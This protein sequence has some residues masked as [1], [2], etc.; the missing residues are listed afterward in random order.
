MLAGQQLADLAG[1]LD[2]RVNAEE[3]V[4]AGGH[5]VVA[6]GDGLLAH[7]LRGAAHDGKL[8]DVQAGILRQLGGQDHH[9]GDINAGAHVQHGRDVGQFAHALQAGTAELLGVHRVHEAGLG[10]GLRGA[11]G[12]DEDDIVGDELLHELDVG[13]V[14]ADLR[15]VA[16]D[17]GDSAAENAGGDALEQGL[18]G[19]EGVDLAVGNAVEDLNDGF[20]G[21]ADAGVGDLVRN[22]D[23]IGLAVREVLNGHLHN[24]LGVLTGVVGGEADELGV[25]H[26]GDGGGGDELRME[27][28]RERAEGREDALHI[29]DDGFACARKDNVLLRQEVA[30]HRDAVAHGDLVR[31]AA[32]A[33]DVD[34]LRADALGKRDHF[35]IIGIVNDHLGQGGIVA[36]DDD[37][38]HIL[39]HYADVGRGV[40]GLRRAKH[41]VGELGA[42]HGAAPAVGQAAAE[43]LTDQCLGQGGAAHM[44]HVQSGRDLAVNGARLDLRLVP[45][46]LRV[47][48]SALQEALHAEGLAVFHQADLGHLVRQLIDVLS[49]GLDAPLMRDADELL[50]VL[51]L[52]VAAFLRLMQGVHD[53]TAMIRVGGRAAGGELQEVSADDAVHVA[54]ADAARS[55]WGDTAGAHGANTAASTGFAKAAVRRLVFHTLLPGIRANLL[56]GFKQGVGR[57]FHLFNSD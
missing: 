31:G 39:L 4:N 52:I 1:A 6:D 10:G 54:A 57:F 36:V 12:D 35:G 43:G 33:A 51:D 13:I 3:G 46:L 55:L 29:D 14:G 18:R 19:A 44:G 8:G 22:V 5:D 49:F 21:I 24:G 42:H 9:T 25:R 15:I 56:A 34:A 7:P 20:E 45:Q 38:D 28:L 50:G 17:H 23:Q 47:L 41:D 16:A 40:H 30:G 2:V 11:A 32:D 27:A 53:L 37:V 48:R 26:A